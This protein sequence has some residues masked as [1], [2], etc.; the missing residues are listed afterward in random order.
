MT[1]EPYNERAALEAAL[2]ASAGAKRAAAES[3]GISLA[4]LWRKMQKYGLRAD[5]GYWRQ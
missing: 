2:R 5:K 1:D 4:T 3:L